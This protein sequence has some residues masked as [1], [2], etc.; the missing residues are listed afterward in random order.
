MTEYSEYIT[1]G[2]QVV[3]LCLKRITTGINAYYGMIP[4]KKYLIIS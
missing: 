1:G 2:Y 3:I 4:M